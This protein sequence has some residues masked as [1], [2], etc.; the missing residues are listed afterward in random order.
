MILK[1]SCF[2]HLGA[3]QKVRIVLGAF[4]ICDA[5]RGENAEE[6][7]RRCRGDEGPIYQHAQRAVCCRRDAALRLEGSAR[8]SAWDIEAAISEC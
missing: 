5:G 4:T 8:P 6:G 1:V 3:L 7:R 2:L